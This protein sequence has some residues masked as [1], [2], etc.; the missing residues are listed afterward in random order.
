MARPQK[1]KSGSNISSRR[2][3]KKRRRNIQNPRNNKSTKNKKKPRRRITNTRLERGLGAL[4]KTNDIRQA[5]RASG[6]SVDAFERKAKRRRAIRKVGGQWIVARRLQRRMPIFSE[7]RHLAISV[8]SRVASRIG[9]YM[10]AV[11]QFLETNVPEHLAEFK[12][13]SVKDINGRLYQFEADPNALYRLSSAGNEPF[14]DVYR[15]II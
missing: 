1:R 7:G 3:N 10:S 13:R 9:H 2:R 14:E 11:G 8:R 4:S 6:T 15:I 12:G 5:A